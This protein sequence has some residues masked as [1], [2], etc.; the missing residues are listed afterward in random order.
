MKPY[1]IQSILLLLGPTFFAAS[2]YMILGR[3]IRLTNGEAHSIVRATLVTKIFLVGD[4]LSFL[5]QSSGGG[6]LAKAK[7][8]DDQKSGERI[9]IIGLFIQI[10]FFGFFIV[11]SALFHYRISLYPTARSRNVQ[12]PWQRYLWILYVASGLIMVRSIYRLLEYI[13][14]KDGVLQSEEA[15]IYVLDA[16]LMFIVAALFNV[17]H[18]SQIIN[19]ESMAAGVY[20]VEMEATENLAGGRKRG[21]Y[22][23]I[24]LAA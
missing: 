24:H 9:I 1:I 2:I 11:V 14:G 23:N 12:V 17:F 10:A 8:A 16:A 5:A 18:P 15:Y 19:K 3:L 6:M 21:E 7:T 22:E 20:D 13:Q 4:I